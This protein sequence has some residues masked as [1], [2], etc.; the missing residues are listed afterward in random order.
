M[1]DTHRCVSDLES[2][3]SEEVDPHLAPHIG[4]LSSCASTA[5]AALM[6]VFGGVMKRLVREL[7]G[8]DW[9]ARFLAA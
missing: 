1:H 8:F 2:E 7:H 3:F 4:L 5:F 9:C 6:G